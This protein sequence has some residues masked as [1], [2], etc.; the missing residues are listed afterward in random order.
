MI[1]FESMLHTT[2]QDKYKL[3]IQLAK[4]NVLLHSEF[5]P[6]LLLP[7]KTL[8]L[9]MQNENTGIITILNFPKNVHQI[10][11]KCTLCILK[12]FLSNTK[13]QH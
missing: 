6:N 1:N 11:K 8:S 2:F 10:R 9:A 12:I 5:L 13:S 4:A 7:A 3:Q